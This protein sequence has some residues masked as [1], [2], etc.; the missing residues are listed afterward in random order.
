LG[1]LDSINTYKPRTRL[2]VP[3]L[4]YNLAVSRKYIHKW[5]IIV[6]KNKLDRVRLVSQAA[7]VIR[8]GPTRTRE[9]KV[10]EVD[11]QILWKLFANIS[12]FTGCLNSIEYLPYVKS[13]LPG[14]SK[15][16]LHRQ[17]GSLLGF[18]QSSCRNI[19]AK[20]WLD[21][22]TFFGFA[23]L[24]IGGEELL[25]ASITMLSGW[26]EVPK[27]TASE[28]SAREGV[29]VDM[30]RVGGDGDVAGTREGKV[31]WGAGFDSSDVVQHT[32]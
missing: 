3:K 10:S 18:L 22:H 20:A 31:G 29:R 17:V 30:A 9:S 13:P 4:I 1:L 5:V 14:F 28:E 12:S 24:A 32:S 6:K 26:A 8:Q 25:T 11:I 21:A 7:P 23:W 19:W 16:P 2:T 15:P 27:G